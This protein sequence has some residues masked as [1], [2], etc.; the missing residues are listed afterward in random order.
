MTFDDLK[1]GPHL[2]GWKDGVQAVVSFENGYGVSVIRGEYSYGG[3]DGLY[4]L[5]ITK[6]REDGGWDLCYDSGL[7]EDVEGYLTPE[8]V[9]S[10]L[11]R[12][13]ALA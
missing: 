12:I 1:F 7:T 6:T 8:D 10:W 5:A 11:K 3:R 9:T 4:E 13:E 2:N